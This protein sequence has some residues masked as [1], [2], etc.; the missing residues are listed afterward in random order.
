MPEFTA[1]FD[2]QSAE[3][4]ASIIAHIDTLEDKG[5]HLGRPLVDTVKGPLGL[6]IRL[7]TFGHIGAST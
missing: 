7:F 5:P 3:L 2:A 4:R 6:S 1:W